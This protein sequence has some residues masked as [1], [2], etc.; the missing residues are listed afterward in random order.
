MDLE[1]LRA[2]ARR[3][4][5][6]IVTAA[7]VLFATRG[8]DAPMDDVARRA[9]VGKGTLYRRFPDRESLIQAV[10]V[11][12]YQRLADLAA[13][14]RREE[15]DAWSALQRFLTHW[16]ELRLGVLHSVLCQR[17][18]QALTADEELRRARQDW[19]TAFDRIVTGAQADGALRSD[20]S[21]GDIA[22]FMVLLIRQPELPDELT[23]RTCRR[24]LQLMLDGLR[25]HRA[26]TLSSEPITSADLDPDL[27]DTDPTGPQP[28]AR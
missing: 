18:P 24:L 13:A 9:G 4:R 25:A 6:Q 15:P 11:D 28:P 8:V 14:A 23:D 10:A 5:E 20:V 19:L 3:N 27:T 12:V 1:L 17:L 26:N 22:M 16:A 21:T 2:D 7:R